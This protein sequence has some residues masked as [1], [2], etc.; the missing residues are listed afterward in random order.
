MGP[1]KPDAINQSSISE[2]SGT[3]RKL[4]DDLQWLGD[5]M[6][7]LRTYEALRSIEVLGEW[8]ELKRDDVRFYAEGRAG[9]HAKLAAALEP[10]VMGCEWKDGF[11]FV[12]FVRTRVYDSKEV[13]PF[14]LPGVL[15][16]F[17]IDEL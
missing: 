3:W 6:V 5:S 16:Y 4:S 7:A 17:D 2:F 10:K 11:K 15:R 13:K 1:L 12:D 14:S 9:V 8:P